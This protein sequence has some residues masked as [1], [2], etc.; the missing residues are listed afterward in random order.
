VSWR[1]FLSRAL[2]GVRG[3]AP[4]G[5]QSLNVPFNWMM[6]RRKKQKLGENHGL[7]IP[8]KLRRLLAEGSSSQKLAEKA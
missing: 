7:F 8:Q 5:E 3:N 2:F 4:G 6:S 1:R